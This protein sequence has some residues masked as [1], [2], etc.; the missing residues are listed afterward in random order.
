[1]PPEL[2]TVVMIIFQ[3]VMT[4]LGTVIFFMVKRIVSSID[5]LATE[6]ASILALVHKHREDALARFNTITIEMIRH[7]NRR[8]RASAHESKVSEVLDDERG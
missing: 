2:L 3:S 1:M 7:D 5:R 6:D 8:F 4:V